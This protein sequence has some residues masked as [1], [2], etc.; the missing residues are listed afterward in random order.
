MSKSILTVTLCASLLGGAAYILLRAEPGGHVRAT[1]PLANHRTVPEMAASAAH[2]QKSL[3]PSTRAESPQQPAVAADDSAPRVFNSDGEAQLVML[4]ELT[5]LLESSPDDCEAIAYGFATILNAHPNRVR[6]FVA[7]PSMGAAP[8]EALVSATAQRIERI[9]I[10]LK[11][12]MPKCRA[13]L[14]PEL[15]RLALA[16]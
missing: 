3:Q 16:D 6:E 4:D 7:E 10:A 1:P 2:P 14:N 13:E 15:R 11:S 5:N 9:S 8:S 12:T